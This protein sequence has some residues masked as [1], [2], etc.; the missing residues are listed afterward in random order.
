[1]IPPRSRFLPLP[2]QA[3]RGGAVGDLHFLEDVLNVL[4]RRRAADAEGARDF[5][6]EG[7]GTQEIEHFNLAS[8]QI[9][10]DGG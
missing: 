9:P 1:M 2:A 10:F 6:I 3:H 5:L 7:S 4:A 8:C